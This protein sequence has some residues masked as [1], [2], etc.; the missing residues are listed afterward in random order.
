MGRTSLDESKFKIR[1]AVG[2]DMLVTWIWIPGKAAAAG[3]KYKLDESA[4]T[5]DPA[6][7][8]AGAPPILGSLAIENA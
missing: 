2:G 6:E 3:I 5:R 1:L 8:K 7:I 4:E